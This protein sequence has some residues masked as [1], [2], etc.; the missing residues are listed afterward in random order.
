MHRAAHLLANHEGHDT[1]GVRAAYGA[2]VTE[3]GQQRPA[4]PTLAP[5]LAHFLKV[6]AS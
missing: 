3:I 2:L 6:T 4:V 5:A 1:D